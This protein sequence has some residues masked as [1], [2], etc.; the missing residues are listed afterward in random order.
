[1]LRWYRADPGAPFTVARTRWGELGRGGCPTRIALSV[2]H[3]LPRAMQHGQF[4]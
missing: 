3:A 1:M 2:G 4:A